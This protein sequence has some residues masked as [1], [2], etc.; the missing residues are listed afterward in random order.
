M[1]FPLGHFVLNM[2]EYCRLGIGSRRY[3][4]FNGL[5]HSL[6]VHR[7]S[8]F[9]WLRFSLTSWVIKVGNFLWNKMDILG[10]HL[11]RQKHPPCVDCRLFQFYHTVWKDDGCVMLSLTVYYLH[12]WD[13]Q[14]KLTN[15]LIRLLILVHSLPCLNNTCCQRFGTSNSP[16]ECR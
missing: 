16:D 1:L 8:R 10:K 5:I 7:M 12:L 2:D 4:D 13:C 15:L 11:W 3:R 6:C 14:V 9:I